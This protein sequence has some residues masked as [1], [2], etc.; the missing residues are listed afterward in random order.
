MKEFTV[1][2]ALAGM[3]VVCGACERHAWKET[4]A[5]HEE[6]GHGGGHG[7]T[8]VK[9]GAAAHEGEAEQ[10]KEKAEH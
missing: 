2:L 4:K 8:A 10:A 7:E 3:V 6:H 9:H 1:M 5:L